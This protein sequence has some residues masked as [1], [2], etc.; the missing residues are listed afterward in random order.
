M[1]LRIS[2]S[3]RLVYG[4]TNFPLLHF[5]KHFVAFFGLP[6]S[7]V[8]TFESVSVC[9]VVRSLLKRFAYEGLLAPEDT[10]VGLRREVAVVELNDVSAFV[11][12]VSWVVCRL[13]SVP[14]QS[15]HVFTPV[16]LTVS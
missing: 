11:A 14:I 8:L 6:L 2:L 3:F 7:A 16:C 1:Y 9:D 13:R 4:L 12:D 15:K 10:V 5:V